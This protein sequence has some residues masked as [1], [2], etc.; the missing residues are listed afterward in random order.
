MRPQFSTEVAEKNERSPHARAGVGRLLTEHYDASCSAHAGGHIDSVC[1]TSAANHGCRLAAPPFGVR[2][3][4][5]FE[6]VRG[7]TS[8]A[9]HI[10]GAY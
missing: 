6:S 8:V 1:G 9:K 5:I 10:V 2:T 7:V 3:E 4:P